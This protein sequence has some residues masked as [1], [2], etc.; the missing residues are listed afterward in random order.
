M[1]LFDTA[2]YSTVNF[3]NTRFASLLSLVGMST[4]PS[5]STLTLLTTE[6][7]RHQGKIVERHVY[8]TV[9]K[10]ETTFK[11]D[12]RVENKLIFSY[13]FVPRS[14]SLT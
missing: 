3:M 10:G 9:T 1:A 5:L 12:L 7:R 13:S 2:A 8:V 11:R 14:F 6:C 4:P